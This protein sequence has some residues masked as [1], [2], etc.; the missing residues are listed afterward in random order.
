M[1]KEIF[2]LA[3]RCHKEYGPGYNISAVLI[4]NVNIGRFRKSDEK[5]RDLWKYIWGVY[6]GE[7]CCQLLGGHWTEDEKVKIYDGRILD[8]IEMIDEH[9]Q[10]SRSVLIEFIKLMK[11]YFKDEIKKKIVNGFSTE[12]AMQL[13]ERLKKIDENTESYSEYKQL[14]ELSMTDEEFKKT[15]T[16]LKNKVAVHGDTKLIFELGKEL[17]E[18]RDLRH[19]EESI[20][21]LSVAENKGVKEAELLSLELT[22]RLKM[23]KNAYSNRGWFS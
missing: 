20:Y 8:P 6:L 18:T 15:M 14:H 11:E 5:I 10:N 13:I 23:L 21:W 7:N 4:L 16:E 3:K 2:E 17:Y 12:Q 19:I 1:R 9:I 22:N